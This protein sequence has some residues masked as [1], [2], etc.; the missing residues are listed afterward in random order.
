M[1][2]FVC[3]FVHS[4]TPITHNRSGYYSFN[5]SST[6][7]ILNSFDYH[8][9][10]SRLQRYA[11]SLP[12]HPSYP[13]LHTKGKGIVV[14]ESN[15]LPISTLPR[16]SQRQ[17]RLTHIIKKQELICLLPK[18]RLLHPLPKSTP[19]V[20]SFVHFL[21]LTISF[22]SLC[23]AKIKNSFDCLIISV[24]SDSF[25]ALTIGNDGNR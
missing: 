21:V 22:P 3:P 7:P 8:H 16:I 18:R 5:S 19:L 11:C 25:F 6:R 15:Q 17:C 10:L 13:P 20:P 24:S 12:A 4:S 9:H 2:S 23:K 14:V 1:H